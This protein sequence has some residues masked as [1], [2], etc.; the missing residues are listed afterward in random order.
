MII[1]SRYVLVHSVQRYDMS[2]RSLLGYEELVPNGD[3]V[4]NGSR[5]L[6]SAGRWLCKAVWSVLAMRYA[7]EVKGRSSWWLGRVAVCR[8]LQRLRMRDGTRATANQRVESTAVMMQRAPVKGC[9]P[10]RP[11][12][13]RGPTPPGRHCV[14]H[15]VE[16]RPRRRS[17]LYLWE[18]V[19]WSL[20]MQAA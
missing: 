16:R 11:R 7:R 15:C 4:S 14:G 2:R 5:L 1:H 10:A 19:A 3:M 20:E 6:C 9:T 12:S 17:A 13:S 8:R 18:A